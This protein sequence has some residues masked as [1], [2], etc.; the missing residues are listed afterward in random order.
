[1]FS[2]RAISPLANPLGNGGNA[3]VYRAQ[4]TDIRNGSDIA[5]KII[6]FHGS[7][8]QQKNI[9]EINLLTEKLEPILALRHPNLVHHI[10]HQRMLQKNQFTKCGLPTELHCPQYQIFM[11]YC[12]GGTLHDYVKINHLTAPQLQNWTRQLVNGLTYLHEQQ[13]VHRDIKGDNIFLTS[14]E[15]NSCLKI[16]DL[17]DIKQLVQSLTARREVSHDKGTFAFMSP[18]MI[19]GEQNDDSCIVG[20]RTDIWSLGCVVI[21]MITGHAPRFYKPV[22]KGN[23][24]VAIKEQLAIM[25]FVGKG[26]SPA[27]P[28]DLPEPIM[29]FLHKCFLR[30]STDRPYAPDLKKH[31]FLT[32]DDVDHWTLPIRPDVNEGLR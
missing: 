26:G 23:G 24:Y 19:L 5:V 7:D 14:A 1:M 31:P 12:A 3:S 22:V 13:C 8:E 27:I 4:R 2:F 6:L 9:D 28:S 25:Y 21:Q 18:E 15:P 29:D 32:A 16:G 20:R 30:K 11:E 10:F 17:G